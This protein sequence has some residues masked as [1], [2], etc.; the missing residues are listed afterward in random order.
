MCALTKMAVL[1]S[2]TPV[3]I[4]QISVYYILSCIV[5]LVLGCNWPFL[6]VVKHVNKLT[7]LNW[8]TITITSHSQLQ[9]DLI[10]GYRLINIV[11]DHIW[12]LHL[13]KWYTKFIS[14][15]SLYDANISS[16]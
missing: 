7:E 15:I 16:F 1:C 10:D 3:I 13:I 8:I 5:V 11:A 9:I 14:T 4:M 2:S 6:A 12:Q